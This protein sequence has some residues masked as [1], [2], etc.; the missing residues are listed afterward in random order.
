VNREVHRPKRRLSG[1]RSA[2]H[3]AECLLLQLI[4]PNQGCRRH[5]VG[6]LRRYGAGPIPTRCFAR[7]SCPYRVAHA[8]RLRSEWDGSVARPECWSNQGILPPL[9]PLPCDLINYHSSLVPSIEPSIPKLASGSLPPFSSC[10]AESVAGKP[11]VVPCSA[12]S[13]FYNVRLHRSTNQRG[14]RVLEIEH[15][16]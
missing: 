1:R 2:N 14:S 12:L 4:S 7:Q 9:A 11:A 10:G 15:A 3:S 8:P 6:S 13:R 16:S 5:R